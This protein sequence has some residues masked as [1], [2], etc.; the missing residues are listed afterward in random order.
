[1]VPGKTI[2]PAIEGACGPGVAAKI[3]EQELSIARLDQAL[4]DTFAIWLD[5]DDHGHAEQQRQQQALGSAP[6]EGAARGLRHHGARDAGDEEDDFHAPAVEEDQRHVQGIGGV[7]AVHV[8]VPS[9]HVQQ[10]GV[11]ASQQAEDE[12]A[13]GVDIVAAGV[14]GHDRGRLMKEAPA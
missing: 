2:L 8:K 9:I 7:A 6:Q 4:A 3:M 1:M 14:H 13:Q 12:K 11:I 5:G 10:G